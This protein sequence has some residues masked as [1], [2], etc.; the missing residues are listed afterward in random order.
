M[1]LEDKIAIVTG[2]G[3]GIGRATALAFARDGANVVV[4]A[5]TRAQ[6]EQVADEVAAMGRQAL[7]L[8]VDV[9]DAAAVEAMTRQVFDT[10]GRVDILVNGA[11]VI[12]RH[13]VWEMPVAAW[14]EMIRVN[15]RGVF[16]CTKAVIEPM[17]GQGSGVIINISS[18]AG[19]RGSAGRCAYSASKF[20]VIG[21]TE[22]VADEVWQ[23]GIRVTVICPGFVRTEM[24]QRGFPDADWSR[25]MDPDDIA[26][27]ALFLATQTGNAFTPEL[28]VRTLHPRPLELPPQR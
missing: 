18:G 6:V 13:P 1:R 27:A 25:W 7:A 17:R 5:R 3:R 26:Q 2:G 21:F 4:V 20:G 24:P 11:G 12:H 23:D 16:L 10:F 19:K 28:V 15:L 8:A 22:S 14:D 9:A